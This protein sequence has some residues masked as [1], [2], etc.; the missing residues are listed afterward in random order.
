M[1]HAAEQ[2]ALVALFLPMFVEIC[3]R[4][5]DEVGD[6]D[7][8]C[9]AIVVRPVERHRIFRGATPPTA[10][11]ADAHPKF[12][13]VND[14]SHANYRWL[15]PGVSLFIRF[16]T[17]AVPAQRLALFQFQFQS[18][19]ASVPRPP[20]ILAAIMYFVPVVVGFDMSL[21]A[22][23]S[24]DVVIFP[25]PPDLQALARGGGW[26]YSRATLTLPAG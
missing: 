12:L 24:A 19:D 11:L 16:Q 8:F 1:T 5:V 2:P 9:V 6:A 10:F 4:F 15:C 21:V 13:G 3:F 26:I 7:D 23:L 18:F 25:F 20:R 22:A 14:L 17:M